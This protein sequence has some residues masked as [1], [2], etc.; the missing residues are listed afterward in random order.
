MNKFILQRSHDLIANYKMIKLI[1][2]HKYTRCYSV[3]VQNNMI[4]KM[5]MDK[6]V[7]NGVL[8]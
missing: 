8:L 3:Q 2:S 6:E 4:A 7:E 5:T 1:D